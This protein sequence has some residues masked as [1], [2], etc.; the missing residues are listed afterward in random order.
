MTISSPHFLVSTNILTSLPKGSHHDSLNC[1]L[2]R[3][4]AHCNYVSAVRCPHG[5][6]SIMA[7]Y[8][9]LRDSRIRRAKPAKRAEMAKT[10]KILAELCF[11]WSLSAQQVPPWSF[12]CRTGQWKAST[13]NQNAA[14]R[15]VAV[16]LRSD[17]V[18]HFRYFEQRRG[19]PARARS[20]CCAGS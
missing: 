8:S 10:L 13:V 18:C 9:V 6:E 5:S 3:A 19:S 1:G 16:R 14:Q 4:D 11:G 20:S 12:R 15:H 17:A 2:P 7:T